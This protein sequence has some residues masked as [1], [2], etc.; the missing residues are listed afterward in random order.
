MVTVGAL[1]NAASRTYIRGMRQ[2]L[3]TLA[4]APGLLHA[5]ELAEATS[6]Y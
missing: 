5:Q 1:V 4:M 3:L 6:G 2:F